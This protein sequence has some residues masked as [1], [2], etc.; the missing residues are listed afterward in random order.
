MP[1][2][3]E[4][5][6][7]KPFQEKLKA[8]G[9]RTW[10]TI[11]YLSALDGA[12]KDTVFHEQIS[13]LPKDYIHLDEMAR[14]EKEYSLNVFDFFFEPT[15]EIICDVIKSTLDFYYSNSPTFRRL[16]NYKVDYSMNN[17]IDTSK[18]EVKVSPNYSYENTEGDSV[19]LS[20]P[21]DKK[22]FPIDPGFHDCETRITSEKVFLDLF[23][24][25]LLYDELKMN[26]EAT[27][28][29]SNV[30]FKEIDSPAMAH[31]SLC[32]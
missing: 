16:V 29:Y 6:A 23:L 14:D 4:H 27:N 1:I 9:I 25:H 7:A 20:L 15:S 19:Y 2:T 31:A 28:I 12:Y 3:L 11:Q 18:C 5:I 13:N 21:F 32:F 30:I 22:G 17:D 24:K 10:D 26:Y 8:K